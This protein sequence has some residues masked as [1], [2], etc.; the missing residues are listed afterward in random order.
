MRWVPA[1]RTPE[2][3]AEEAAESEGAV[4]QYIKTGEDRRL[5]E[6]AMRAFHDRTDAYA[7]GL[8]REYLT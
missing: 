5:A 6:K 1:K 2:V 8:A 7:R 3:E 4:L